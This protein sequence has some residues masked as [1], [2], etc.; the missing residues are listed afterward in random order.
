MT[1]EQI[2]LSKA[3]E[4]EFTHWVYWEEGDFHLQIRYLS[5][6]GSERLIKECQDKEWD[7]KTHQRVEKVNEE[8]FRKKIADL[9]V[10]WKGLTGKRAARFV[11]LQ[12]GTPD[13]GDVPFTSE[14]KEFAMKNFGSLPSFVLDT[15]KALH[16]AALDAEETEIKNS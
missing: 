5:V 14:N 2:S 16:R 11:K 12:K 8:R 9:L 1:T 3:F 10:G 7:S 6:E 4:P 15:A 13:D